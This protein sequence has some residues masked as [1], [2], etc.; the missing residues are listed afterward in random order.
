MERVVVARLLSPCRK[1]YI[2]GAPCIMYADAA[3]GTF[4]CIRDRNCEGI[5]TGVNRQPPPVPFDAN[6]GEITQF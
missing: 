6:K 3:T 4:V 1:N 5:G 2:F